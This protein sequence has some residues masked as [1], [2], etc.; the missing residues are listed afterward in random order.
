MAIEIE[1]KFQVL[2]DRWR[3]SASAGS[4]LRQAYLIAT[5]NRTLRVRTIDAE[6]ATLT[7]KFRR[8]RMR[9]EE[10][11]YAI[12]YSDALQ[13]FEFA[14]GIVEKTRYQVRYADHLWHIDVY[15]G[16]NSGLVVAEIELRNCWDDPPHPKW[17][18]P[19]ITENPLYSNR[20]LAMRS[21]TSTEMSPSPS[22]V[23]RS[24]STTD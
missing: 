2:D 21:R 22:P 9:R 3:K 8:D 24:D 16:A 14:L 17:L 23:G 10:Y 18:G 7:A 11:E 5:K 15:S 4:A 13:M 12:P 20:A 6:R 19:E 1:R